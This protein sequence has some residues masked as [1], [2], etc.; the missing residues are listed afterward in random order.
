MKATA[1]HPYRVEADQAERES[2]PPPADAERAI[3]R[4][5]NGTRSAQKT[6]IRTLGGMLDAGCWMLD[7]GCWMLD[8]TNR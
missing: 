8:A 4:N 7:A 2:T 3:D 5:I 1:I 6:P